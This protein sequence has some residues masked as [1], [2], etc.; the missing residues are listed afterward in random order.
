MKPICKKC[1]DNLLVD[2]V[3]KLTMKPETEI[4]NICIKVEER[5][6]KKYMFK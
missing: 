1:K 5:Y 2:D 3:A 6:I 4:V